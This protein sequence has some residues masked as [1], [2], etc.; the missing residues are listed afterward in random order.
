[1]S[2]IK[3]E[4]K[5]K[6]YA[7]FNG[8]CAYCGVKLTEFNRT[9]DHIHPKVKGG[10]NKTENLFPSCGWCNSVKCD[11]SIEEFRQ[12]VTMRANEYAKCLNRKQIKATKFYYEKF[13][14]N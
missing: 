7:M 13:Q 9:I 11:R 3:A 14:T 12:Y 10:T 1:M 4:K 8:K 6:I 2:S 5:A